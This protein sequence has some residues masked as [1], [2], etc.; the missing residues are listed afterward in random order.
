MTPPIRT[1]IMALMRLWRRSL[2][3]AVTATGLL[4]SP[5]VAC[6]SELMSSADEQMD[7]CKSGQH[8]CAAT[9]KAA[10]CCTQSDSRPQ[11]LGASK[12]ESVQPLQ[13]LLASHPA[14]DSATARASR[15]CVFSTPPV[16]V[17]TSPPDCIS[18]SAL[19][20]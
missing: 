13:M 18:F 19:L 2:I 20:I 8:D 10:D 11:Q 12:V 16:P 5:L 17:D 7:C 15:V 1:C 4:A 9:M 3:V 6:A 14:W